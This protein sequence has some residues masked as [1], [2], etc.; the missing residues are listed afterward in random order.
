MN[1]LSPRK[2]GCTTA[3]P[4]KSKLLPL[5]LFSV[6][7]VNS[8]PVDA[9][10]CADRRSMMEKAGSKK[11]DL[12]SRIGKLRIGNTALKKHDRGCTEM[13]KGARSAHATQICHSCAIF[14]HCNF[15]RI[16]PFFVHFFA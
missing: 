14:F 2:T 16:W 15:K 1:N 5:L 10:A 8:P 11:K 13:N 9:G 3:T 7:W 12:G 4:T 6:L